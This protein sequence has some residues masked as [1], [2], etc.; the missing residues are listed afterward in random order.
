MKVVST[1]AQL[2]G[3][4]LAVIALEALCFVAGALAGPPD[5]APSWAPLECPP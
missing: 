2:I 4:L 3:L 1:A 5:R